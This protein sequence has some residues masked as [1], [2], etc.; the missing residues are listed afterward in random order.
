MFHSTRPRIWLPLRDA[1]RKPPQRGQHSATRP[2]GNR[3]RLS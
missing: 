2:A 3:L 1:R